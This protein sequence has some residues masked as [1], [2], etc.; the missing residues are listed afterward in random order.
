MKKLVTTYYLEMPEEKDFKP[1][2]GFSDVLEI[3]EISKDIFQHWMLFVGV[4]LPWKWYSRLKWSP[5]D[6]QQYFIQNR[7][8]TFM[9]FSKKGLVGYFELVFDNSD[10][11]E[12]KFFGLFPSFIG[13]GYGGALLSHAVDI[14]WKQNATKVWLHTCTSDHEA[15][16]SNYLARGFNLV[17]QKEEV[18]SIPDKEEYLELV[19]GFMRLYIETQIR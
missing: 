10:A 3:K 13:D 9:A 7:V 2:A 18:E 15:A 5:A 4:G 14:A 12:I 19:N 11:A 1:K 6:W 16:L 17:N 8:F